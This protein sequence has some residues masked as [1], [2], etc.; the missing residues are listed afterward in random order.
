MSGTN[1]SNN[2]LTSGAAASAA[3]TVGSANALSGAFN[4]G[5][6]NWMGSQYLNGLTGNPAVGSPAYMAA[7]NGLSNFITGGTV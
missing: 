4:S 2:Y 6:N 1:A 3:G 7:G 5:I